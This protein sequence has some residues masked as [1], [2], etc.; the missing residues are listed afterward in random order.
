MVVLG[1]VA[2]I[3]LCIAQL[4]TAATLQSNTVMDAH[5]NPVAGSTSLYDTDALLRCITSQP[6]AVLTSPDGGGTD[7]ASTKSIVTQPQPPQVSKCTTS[8][9]ALYE[10]MY[11][12]LQGVAAQHRSSGCSATVAAPTTEKT[13]ENV[14]MSEL[15]LDCSCRGC[16]SVPYSSSLPSMGLPLLSPH[17]L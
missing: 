4:D 10:S 2:A 12:S 16:Q 7:D 14:L 15:V 17:D 8:H 5:T 3:V 1:R 6:Y 9:A 11:Q 13:Q